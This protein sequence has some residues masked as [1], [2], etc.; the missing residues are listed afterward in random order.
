MYRRALALDPRRWLAYVNLLE[1]MADSPE[2]WQR[3]DEILAFLDRAHAALREDPHGRFSVLRGRG[4]AGAQRGPAGRGPPPPR[5]AARRRAGP[6]AAQAG[7]RHPAGHRGGRTRAGPGRLAR[8]GRCRPRRPPRCAGPRST[9]WTGAPPWP[10]TGQR[11]HRPAPHRQR[12]PLP[13]RARA[14]GAGP[15]RRGPARAADAAAAAALARRGLAAAR[16]HPGRTRRRAGGRTGRRGPAQGAGPRAVLARP[17]RA[18]PE[19]GH[20]ARRQGRAPRPPRQPPPRRGRRPCSTRRSAGSRSDVP[21]D[22]PD[23]AGQALADSPGLRRGGRLAVLARR[24]RCRRRRCRRCGTTARGWPAWPPSC[25]KIRHDEDVL[26]AG[27]RPGWIGRWPWARSRRAS[28]GRC[29]APARRH[30][31]RAGR[32]DG[33]RRI[34]GGA[35]PAGRGA[36][37]APTLEPALRE[38]DAGG[39]GAPAAAGRPAR[40]GGAHAGGP[41]PRGAV[42]RVADRARPHRRVPGAHRRGARL[43]PQGAGRRPRSPSA[44]TALDRIARIAARTPP[45]GAPTLPRRW[46]SELQAPGAP[47]SRPPSGR[48]PGRPPRGTLGRGGGAGRAF[49][50]RGRRRRSPARRGGPRAVGLRG[51]ADEPAGGAGRPACG[52]GWWWPGWRLAAGGAAAGAPAARAVGGGRPGPR[53]RPLSRGGAGGGRDPP[54]RAQAP[55]ERARHAGRARR[56]RATEVARALL[57]ADPHLG[58]GGDRIRAAAAGRRRRRGVGAPACPR[59]GVRAAARARWPGPKRCCRMAGPRPTGAR[60]A[61]ARPRCCASSTARPWRRCWRWPPAR[62]WIPRRWPP[63]CAPLGRGGRRS[64]GGRR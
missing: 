16:H 34:G 51:Q 28:S 30:R 35:R 22:G 37:A 26:P 3:R 10:S 29:C 49:P 6:A 43:P 33:L 7:Q 52:P 19:A 24:R 36:R 60:A 61:G 25:C 62:G 11:A 53:A 57:R 17:A 12:R 31:G 46:P 59:A 27:A 23:G 39:L 58:G 21:A 18:A 47:A 4:R 9:C 63:G 42:G 14:G 50:A 1:L 55:G 56:A 5:A 54:R 45:D 64:A 13:A 41:L 20:Q 8:G 15:P 48:W 2:R 38:G 44:R 40:R 32:S